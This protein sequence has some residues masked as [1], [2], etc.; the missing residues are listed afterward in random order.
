[1]FGLY[2]G[3]RL[4]QRVASCLSRT[5]SGTPGRSPEPSS[6]LRYTRMANHRCHR[7]PTGPHH[8]PRPNKTEAAQSGTTTILRAPKRSVGQTAWSPP[9]SRTPPPGAA[10]CRRASEVLAQAL[11]EV[12]GPVDMSQQ[13]AQLLRRQRLRRQ[14]GELCLGTRTD[15]QMVPISWDGL[16]W[17]G[18]SV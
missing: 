14:R 13:E 17:F 3:N 15:W 12:L 6:F 5:F 4:S 9:R 16:G 18:G 10:R 8:S 2:E 1:M 11:M 7:C